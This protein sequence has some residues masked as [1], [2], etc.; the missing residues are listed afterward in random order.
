MSVSL[1]SDDDPFDG[2]TW[3]QVLTL[4][5]VV[6]GTDYDNTE[7]LS[8]RYQEQAPNFPQTLEFLL[9][10]SEVGG[11]T[12]RLR[13]L[14][15]SPNITQ[16]Q[17]WIID[18]LLGFNHV[19][20]KEIDRY[21]QNFSVT[22]GE[23]RNHPAPATRHLQSNVR[24][25]LIELGIV[26]HNIESDYYYVTPAHIRIYVAAEER[27]K[28]RL[29]PSKR[30]SSQI[31]REELGTAAEDRIMEY[32]RDRLGAEYGDQIEHIAAVDAAAGYDIRSVTIDP[33]GSTVPRYIE[34]KAVP[35]ESYRFYW[36]RTEVLT[37]QN[38]GDWYFLYLLPVLRDGIFEM[39]KL[40]QFRNPAH[41][42]LADP[43][44]WDIDSDVLLCSLREEAG[45]QGNVS[46]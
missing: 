30:A 3:R 35:L 27:G 31:E 13:S 38:L 25:F 32:E 7:Y 6:E 44:S 19:Y 43:D 45:E 36:S 17:S 37:A 20:R 5:Q 4:V 12:S 11:E 33:S 22:E 15:S 34:V 28:R 23:P 9:C 16:A 41:S 42:V 26:R 29:S 8:R 10:I 24:N 14:L 18:R 2:L 46:E 39:S 40:K 1:S 21:L